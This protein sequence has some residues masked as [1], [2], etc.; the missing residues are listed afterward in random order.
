MKIFIASFGIACWLINIACNNA[1]VARI[2][3]ENTLSSIDST[4]T[5]S[6][7]K[8]D[9]IVNISDNVDSI[10]SFVN[11]F[12]GNLKKQ[13]PVYV[14][15]FNILRNNYSATS[16]PTEY[17]IE[18]VKNEI[19]ALHVQP[20]LDSKK[21]L[22]YTLSKIAKS[23]NFSF[24]RLFLCTGTSPVFNKNIVFC[25]IKD[26]SSI[27]CIKKMPY[28]FSIKDE[29]KGGQPIF[30][31][32]L[33]EILYPDKVLII[34]NGKVLNYLK[35]EYDHLGRIHQVHKAQQSALGQVGIQSISE[36]NNVLHELEKITTDKFE[37]FC[38]FVSDFYDPLWYIE[39]PQFYEKCN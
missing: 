21:K 36:A 33:N 39:E 23:D 8:V 5:D 7:N 29:S 31:Y 12:V 1:N 38:F 32:H 6:I 13:V 11:G 18:L 34:L 20:F 19:V 25:T 37:S 2:Q 27:I 4:I 9:S 28:N 16:L 17:S 14:N 3:N 10:F 26:D 30:I 35:F 22:S 24:Y 15:Y